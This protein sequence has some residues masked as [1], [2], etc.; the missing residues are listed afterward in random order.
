[1]NIRLILIQLALLLCVCSCSDSVNSPDSVDTADTEIVVPFDI[2][3]GFSYYVH[4]ECKSPYD[5]EKTNVEV[6]DDFLYSSDKVLQKE[7]TYSVSEDQK[8]T[9]LQE[10]SIYSYRELETISIEGKTYSGGFKET[11]I[12]RY[13]EGTIIDEQQLVSVYDSQ[14]WEAVNQEFRNGTLIHSRFTER[15]TDD[16]GP[17]Y[18]RVV[19]NEEGFLYT[20]K[21]KFLN[22]TIELSITRYSADS[23]LY[24]Q[25]ML[26]AE[27][28][29]IITY[30]GSDSSNYESRTDYYYSKETGK[31]DSLIVTVDD[32]VV[33]RY[34]TIFE[35]DLIVYHVDHRVDQGILHKKNRTFDSYNRLE[36]EHLTGTSGER[37]YSHEYFYE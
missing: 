16:Y 28:R 22:D 36:T 19:R 13:K 15:G 24:S 21:S 18:A 8:D 17:T 3:D 4:R 2:P 6:I 11:T 26:D 29:L 12:K 27:G 25:K 20:Q 37:Y 30:T 33:N 35:G 23:I 10:Q 7:R 5:S 34:I 14:G 31:R 9:V 32:V 1:M